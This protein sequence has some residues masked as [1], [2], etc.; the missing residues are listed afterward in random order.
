MEN[1]LCVIGMRHLGNYLEHR[2][3]S[4]VR[5]MYPTPKAISHMLVSLDVGF[6]LWLNGDT[7]ELIRYAKVAYCKKTP[8]N[9]T[10]SQRWC[11]P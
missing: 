7:Q 9:T 1:V 10:C 5:N 3:P 11:P 4:A 2:A 8:K 6:E